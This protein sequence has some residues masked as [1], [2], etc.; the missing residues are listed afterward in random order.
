ME[1]LK[2]STKLYLIGGLM[3]AIAVTIGVIGIVGIRQTNAGLETVYNDRVVPLKQLKGIADDY[4]VAIIDAANKCNAGM[5]SAEETL[6]GLNAAD[7]RIHKGWEDYMAT[8]LT[9]EE[10]RLAKEAEGLFK[11]ADAAVERLRQFLNN[12]SGNLKGQLL[13]FDG[14]LYSYIDP[15]SSKVTELVDLQLR[16]AQEE[17]TAAGAR[18][19]S[20]LWLCGGVLTIGVTVIGG[21]SWRLIQ[22]VVRSLQSINDNL[23]TGAAQ[24]T[25]AANQVS[26]ASQTLAGGASQQAAALEETS[27][28]LEEISSMTS[29]NSENAKAAKQL[30]NQTRAAADAGATHMNEMTAAMNGIKTSSATVAKI[31]KTI[32]EIAFQTNLLAL[33]AA[34]EAARAGEAGAG[35]AIVADE[36]RNLAQR[37][38]QAAKETAEK[39]ESA[40]EQS[41]QGVAI[42]VKVAASL[43]EMVTQVRQMDELV[44]EIATASTEQSSGVAQ[45]ST[46]TTEMDGVTQANAASAEESASA[47]E[48]L[49]A[50][51]QTLQGM[52]G[53]LHLLV[54]GTKHQPEDPA[55]TNSQKRVTRSGNRLKISRPTLP[56]AA[57][58]DQA[59]A[60]FGAALATATKAQKVPV[61]T[62][63]SFKD[64]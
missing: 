20:V 57:D 54:A 63:G 59:H 3:A 5:L 1:Q 19:Q 44:A 34:V 32:D 55:P 52:V 28:S 51:A 6:Q 8:Q 16:V 21:I 46:A 18:Y 48:E 9:T 42:S 45:I 47:A 38:A 25:Q 10:S 58:R 61:P 60:A 7:A 35:F 56:V 24:I 36:V 50:Q 31:I 62:A 23:M 26:T 2:L 11:S 4:A 41:K 27:A 15:I 40:I 12:K 39:I 17:Y 53:E 14:P 30:A 64:F 49:N 13:E 33:N 43:E 37:S 29:R 22:N